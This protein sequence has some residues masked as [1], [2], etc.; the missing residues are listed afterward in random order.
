MEKHFISYTEALKIIE[1]HSVEFPE[2][3]MPIKDCTHAFLAEGIRADR[4]T[5]PFDRVTMDGIAIVYD[6]FQNGYK[7]FKI[8]A[9]AAAGDTAKKL[10]DSKNCIEV[11]TGAVLP[12]GTDTV[13]RYEDITIAEGVAHINVAT[14]KNGQNIHRKGADI[15]KDTVVITPGKQLSAAEI[16]IAAAYGKASLKVKKMP[17]VTVIST[18]NELVSI[19]EKPLPHQ[20]R[21]SSVYAIRNTL[22][23]WGIIA[24]LVHSPDDKETL[25]TTIREQLALNNV[26]IFTGG[27][28][29]GKFDYL[30][31]VLDELKIDKLFHKVQQRP[32]K[33]F[34]FGKSKEG[35]LI[36]ALP[37][38][39][40]STI[41]CLYVY[42]KHWLF[43][44]LN[45]S[46][47]TI[48][49]KLNEDLEFKLDLTYF[50]AAKLSPNPNG[51]LTADI[52]TGNGSGDF[53]SLAKADGFLVLPQEKTVFKKGEV[54]P[55]IPFRNLS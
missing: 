33:P 46:N 14:I 35:K 9:I 13:I 29:K 47:T 55:F 38:N 34:W 17:A 5:P 25:H 50:P 11:M 19:D 48:Y 36:F 30:P 12:E 2:V 39:P 26:L 28:S 16:N 4:E 52:I 1:K 37:G 7:A 42:I 22:K 10:E 53:V 54:Y 6:R 8:E 31:E 20:I 21:R 49:T 43:Y 15:R 27:V 3:E 40:V 32:G 24:D 45:K 23:E 41:A 51:Y 18:G 44:S